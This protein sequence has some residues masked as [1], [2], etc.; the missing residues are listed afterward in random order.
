MAKKY[1]KKH[2]DKNLKV[3]FWPKAALS[4]YQGMNNYDPL[5]GENFYNDNFHCGIAHEEL[6]RNIKCKTIFMKAQTNS[7]E[8][9]IL[10]AALSED[11]LKKVSKLISDCNIVRF[12]CGH[13]IHI[14]KPKAFIKCVVK[15]K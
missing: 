3:L 11:D 4:G 13:G 8:N 2:P 15:L 9:G 6:L 5:F 7:S 1:R 14:E 12:D 10:M